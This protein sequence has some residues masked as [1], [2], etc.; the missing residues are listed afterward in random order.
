[1]EKLNNQKRRGFSLVE[2]LTV[3][4]IIGI[5]V[6]FLMPALTSARRAAQT[7][8]CA[9]NMR[10]LV[11]ALMNYSVESKGVFPGNIG[12]LN[13]YWYNRDAVGKYIKTTY[14]QSN[15]EQ[16]I[17]GVFICP[18][19]LEGAVRSYAMNLWASGWV[20]DGVLGLVNGP[21]P[22]AK[23]W[24]SS[25]GSSSQMILIIEQFSQEDWPNDDQGSSIGS[26]RTGQWSSKAITG[27]AGGAP[28]ARFHSGGQS[29][30]A[31]F[32]DCASEV[33]YFRHRAPKQPGTLGDA[34][35]R[36]N[37]GFAD[38]HV[39]LVSDKEL[40]NAET[41]QSTYEALW[42]PIDREADASTVGP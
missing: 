8:Q 10:Q 31:R 5:L 18:A 4:G 40:Y 9:S 28:G 13:I 38:G 12:A 39:S 27:L 42:S 11:A 17:G 24:K 22:P 26:G 33:C 14:Q 2:L 35:G 23:L 1:M 21:N 7:V 6:A 30:P 15:S 34:T 36:L 37:I 25:V 41:G 29:I 20:S 3:I 32:G 16:C 19:D